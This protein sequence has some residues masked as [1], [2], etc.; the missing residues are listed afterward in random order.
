MIDMSLRTHSQEIDLNRILRR[1]TVKIGGSG[2][3]HP[4]AAGARIP[5]ENFKDFLREL[6][7][8]LNEK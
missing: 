6:D 2:G 8:N 7:R 4:N 1:I 3:G 5:K